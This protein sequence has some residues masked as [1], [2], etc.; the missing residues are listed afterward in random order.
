MASKEVTV[1]VT[2]SQLERAKALL[3]GELPALPEALAGTVDLRGWIEALIFGKDYAEPD[4]GFLQREMA[5]NVL[6][7]PGEA[8][9]DEIAGLDKL[10]D[11]VSDFPGATTGPI[12]I[13]DLYVVPSQIEEGVNCY[14]ILTY[15]SHEDGLVVRCSGGS[16]AVQMKIIRCLMAGM[17]PIDCEISRTETKLKGGKHMLD[18]FPVH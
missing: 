15:I 5:L 18:V 16:H 8:L 2:G 7:A 11:L 17:W 1:R 10:Q 4:P 9:A 13:T 12:R 14:L 3:G 6:L